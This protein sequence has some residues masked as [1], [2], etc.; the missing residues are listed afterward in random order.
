[1][2]TSLL[3]VYIAR[4]QFWPSF[5][6]ML[7]K[8]QVGKLL[9]FKTQPVCLL[10]S[11]N[12]VRDWLYCC[13]MFYSTVCQPSS[14]DVCILSTVSGQADESCCVLW[15]VLVASVSQVL[16]LTLGCCLWFQS[17][18]AQFQFSSEKVLPSDA[19]RSALAKTFQDEQRFQLGIMD[20]AAEC[21]VRLLFY[22]HFTPFCHTFSL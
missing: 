17:I 21:F 8:D 2:L 1:M 4:L 19:L 7:F 9:G 11:P 22:P 5:T 15:S 3:L 10:I 6:K 16:I 20:D 14:L 18:F 12:K 13:V